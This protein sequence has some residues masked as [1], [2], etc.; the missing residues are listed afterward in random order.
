[1]L[2]DLENGRRTGRRV[3]SLVPKQ[4]ERAAEG[5]T[6]SAYQQA[7][8]QVN[9]RGNWGSADQGAPD[10]EAPTVGLGPFPELP[11]GL[12]GEISPS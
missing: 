2:W 7:K 1:M 5:R 9:T 4:K 12:D 8:R 3:L 6:G 10:R 11:M